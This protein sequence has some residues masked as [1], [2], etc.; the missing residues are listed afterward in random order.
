MTQP[1]R[2]PLPSLFHLILGLAIGAAVIWLATAPQT[3]TPVKGPRVV[4]SDARGACR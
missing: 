2:P 1:E 3:K 4:R